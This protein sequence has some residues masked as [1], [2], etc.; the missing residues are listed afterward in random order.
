MAGPRSV[1]SSRPVRGFE[2]RRERRERAARVE[3]LAV[4][5]AEREG[6]EKESVLR[7][8]VARRAEEERV[9]VGWNLVCLAEEL[10]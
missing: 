3:R 1:R 8:A 10:Y 2:T 6:E 7:G 9:P 4:M 5:V